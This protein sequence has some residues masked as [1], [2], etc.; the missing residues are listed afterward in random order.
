MIIDIWT[1]SLFA[2]QKTTYYKIKK[3][4]LQYIQGQYIT[5]VIETAYIQFIKIKVDIWLSLVKKKSEKL[6]CKETK[7]I[8]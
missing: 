4:G 5:K 3:N 7:R 6:I 2:K 1:E 8:F